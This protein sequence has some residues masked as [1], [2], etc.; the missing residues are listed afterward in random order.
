MSTEM[1]SNT[2][3]IEE[4][5]PFMVLVQLYDAY[6]PLIEDS[7]WPS[8]TNSWQELVFCLLVSIAGEE[9]HPDVL[10]E[11]VRIL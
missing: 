8:E 5:D 1:P 11:T 7:M 6:E 9:V 10:R 3:K 4:Q 2:Q